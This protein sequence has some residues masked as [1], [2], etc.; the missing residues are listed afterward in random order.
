VRREIPD[1]QRSQLT[2]HVGDRPVV[3]VSGD[4]LGTI[5][6]YDVDEAT[7][8]ILR[9]RV[10]G[11]LSGLIGT[12][13]NFPASAIRTFGRDAILVDDAIA[14]GSPHPDDDQD[15]MGSQMLEEEGIGSERA[16]KRH[17]AL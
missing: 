9:Y 5:S 12:S 17:A 3:T 10:G 8:A 4:K 2:P 6:S 15:D 1:T 14:P 13:V 11:P 16:R 7:G